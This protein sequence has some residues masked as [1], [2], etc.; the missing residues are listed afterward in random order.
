MTTRITTLLVLLACT[1]GPVLAA[2][3]PGR[4]PETAATE[5]RYLAESPLPL[6]EV[7]RRTLERHAQQPVFAARR[8]DA[9]AQQRR[10]DSLMAGN[11][12]LSTNYYS[13]TL[14]SG[15]GLREWELGI[16]VPLWRPGQ[17]RA[18][19]EWA[20]A[21][22]DAVHASQAALALATA[23]ELREA[24]WE[25]A[26]LRNEV[27]LAQQELTTAQALERDLEKR[28][29][30]GD[31]AETDLLLA[32]E[33]TLRRRDTHVAAETIYRQALLQYRN[34]TGEALLPRQRR[35]VLSPRTGIG[36]EHP[37]LAQ[38]TRELEAARR[39]VTAARESRVDAP[40]VAL[41]TR[42]ER[43]IAGA[44][45]VDSVG[46]FFTLPFGTRAHTT[47]RVTAAGIAQAEAEARL[48][49]TRR[50]LEAAFAQTE[51]ALRSTRTRL[52][53]AEEH[54]ALAAE[55][56]RLAKV[57]F[58]V[59]ET[60]LINLLRV[61]TLAFAAERK[62]QQLRIALQ[63]AIARYNQAVGVIP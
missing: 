11:P 35:E 7:L 14:N 2:A 41:S 34:L 50:D 5:E 37:V 22:L 18:L 21:S 32:R 36:E 33:E 1:A 55:N 48:L 12:E 25:T 39:G 59:G 15:D 58:S 45:A 23:G 28:V 19:G 38:L 9:A 6:S 16:A 57:A 49:Q 53:L 44:E 60:D 24:L 4:S 43:P 52:D 10:A 8:K 30:F 47:P 20:D 42:Q 29:R 54:Q 27:A 13:D 51:Q 46:V 3:A 31:S 61:Q 26:Q 17:R 62:E 56:L 40:T 63:R